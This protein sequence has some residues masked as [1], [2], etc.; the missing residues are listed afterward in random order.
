MELRSHEKQSMRL[1]HISWNFAGLSLP[2]VMAAIAVP[3][4][5]NLIGQER[6]GILTLAWGLIG[7]A[8]ALDLGIGRATTYA[9]SNLKAKGQSEIE[10]IPVV[11]L[12][13]ARMTTFAGIFGAILMLIV[14]S[15]GAKKILPTTSLETQEIYISALFISLA[16]PM[17]ALSATFRGV[18]EAYLNFKSISILRVLLGMANFGLPLLATIFSQKIYWLIM[19]IVI[20]RGVALLAYRELALQCIS[21]KDN[22]KPR[23]SREVAKN[24]AGFG[25][26]FT[27]SNTL[28][29]IIS[30]ADRFIVVSTVSAAA[31][32]VYVVPYEMV[33]QSLTIVGAITT[34]AFPYL[35]KIRVSDPERASLVF[36][37]SLLII[38]TLMFFVSV[39]Y[40]FV[41]GKVLEIWLGSQYS[42][43]HSSV[44]KILCI[45]LVSYTLGTMSISWLHAHGKTN[46]TAKLNL[47]EFPLYLVLVY[48]LVK[49]YG[50]E[51]AAIAW[52]ARVS[53]NAVFLYYLVLRLNAK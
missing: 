40:F 49:A 45:G 31:V 51:G 37:K 53:L 13:A 52:V 48:L 35:S 39:A 15:I 21:S 12:T 6:F 50:V 4:L 38:L 3:K 46:T 43:Q 22:V 1:S 19:T 18:N 25:G 14:L 20:S 16:L 32:S 23:F 24:L 17:Q 8:G 42:S 33:V 2:L 7:Y 11:L 47:L 36:K 26:W 34:V 41:G 5:L 27:V 30:I 9:I 28:N 44:I 10:Q 29:P